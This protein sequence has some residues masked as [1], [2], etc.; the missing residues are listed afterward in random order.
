VCDTLLSNGIDTDEILMDRA[1]LQQAFTPTTFFNATT[2]P[3][4]KAGDERMHT[5]LKIFVE[6]SEATVLRIPTREFSKV[7]S[8][9]LSPLHELSPA[10]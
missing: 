9:P 10:S 3:I 6:F 2:T 4:L 5:A 8:S 7:S 1:E